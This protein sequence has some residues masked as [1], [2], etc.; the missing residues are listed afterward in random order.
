MSD[1][2]GNGVDREHFRVFIHGKP[3]DHQILFQACTVH[4]H[5][6]DLYC[7]RLILAS[8]HFNANAGREQA[9]TEEGELRWKVARPRATKGKPVAKMVK[10]TATRGK[11]TLMY[12]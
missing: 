5:Y 8:M 4:A 2:S 10:E 3:P 9:V 1:H 7:S 6:I 12:N 11:M